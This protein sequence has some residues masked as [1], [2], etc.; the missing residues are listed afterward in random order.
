MAKSENPPRGAAVA[1]RFAQWASAL[2]DD[3]IPA[4]VRDTALRALIDHAGLTVSARGEPYVRAIVDTW[5]QAGPCTAFG[6]STG[7]DMAGAA[8]INGT[9]AHGED[10]DDTFE[11]SPMHASAVVIPAV[12]A[13]GER[14]GLSGA[15]VLRG[16][17][18]GTELMCRMAIVAPTAQH[19]AGFHPT[20]VAGALGAAAG[21]AAALRMK[22]SEITDALG[23]AGSFASGIIE[24]LA[25]GT[26]TKRIH[27]GWA[28]QSGIRAALLARGGFLGPRT[29]FE[30]EHGFF[31]AFGVGQIKP[32]MTRIT[33]D[34]GEDWHCG[35]IAFK[36]YACGTMVQ[37]FIDCAVRLAGQGI[38]VDRIKSVLCKVGEGTVHRLW[39]PLTEKRRPTTPYSAK[40]SV[41][42]GVAVGLLD[43]AAGLSQ[44]TEERITAADILDLTVKVSYEIDPADEYPR[45]YTGTVIVTLDDGQKFEAHQPYLR[46]GVK[47]TLEME[48]ILT[49]FRANCA[50]GGW[51]ADKAEEL[52]EAAA[53]LFS[54]PDLGRLKAFRC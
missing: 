49:K 30:G 20:A 53:D 8:L 45:N 32:D 25:E 40:F 6:H 54:A 35:R 38:P 5:D 3:A 47:E 15:D 18:V 19:R 39:E 16:M 31:F 13:A 29:V 24:Y 14:F 11:G 12:L 43:R 10:Y 44:F 7:F 1:E 48:E 23:I 17:V 4:S 21:V 42:F 34:L 2:K 33:A 22:D 26:W 51:G 50:F 28:A 37:P 52:A 9:A 41:P 46:G 27:P 36:P